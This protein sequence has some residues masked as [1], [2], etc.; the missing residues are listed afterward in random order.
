MAMADKKTVDVHIYLDYETYDQLCDI[1][2]RAEG[3]V[4][5]KISKHVSKAVQEYVERNKSQQP[6]NLVSKPDSSPNA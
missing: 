1:V 4:S 6:S 3:K 2:K 5:R